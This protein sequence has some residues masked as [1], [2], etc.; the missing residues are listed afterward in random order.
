MKWILC[1][2]EDNSVTTYQEFVK[3]SNGSFANNG[4]IDLCED[5][6]Y[7]HLEELQKDNKDNDLINY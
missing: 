5:C 6:Y 2:A 4:L 7:K 1:G 3:T